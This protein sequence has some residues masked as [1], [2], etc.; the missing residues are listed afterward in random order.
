MSERIRVKEHDVQSAIL[1]W[2]KHKKIFHW[3]SNTGAFMGVHRGKPRF[4]R[5]G[6]KGSPDIFAVVKGQIIGIECK[7]EKGFQ[8]Q[9]QKQFEVEFTQAG[10][11]Y[12][13]AFSLNDVI[14]GLAA[15]KKGA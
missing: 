12:I 15:G 11:V 2:L 1:D 10:G 6:K 7:G 14:S 4:V 9:V 3:R 8:S 5:F 13:L